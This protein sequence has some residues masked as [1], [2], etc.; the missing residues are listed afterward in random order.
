MTNG[1]R[2]IGIIIHITAWAVIFGMPLF[3]T[4][5][6]Q[7]VSWSDY[8][9]FLPVPFSFLI[10]F[11][12]NYFVLIRRFLFSH[13]VGLFLLYNIIATI[14][15]MMIVHA[16]HSL[17]QPIDM[18]N[19]GPRPLIGAISFYAG[20]IAMYLLVVG[21]SVA[22]RM[23]SEWYR[24]EAA[25]KEQ[26]KIGTE[27]ELQ[28]LKSQLNPHFLFNTLN[29]IYSLIQIDPEKA[30]DT[31]HDL[32][33]LLRYVLYE[34]SRETVPVKEE[35]KFLR[36]YMELMKIRLPKH[37]R[38]EVSLPEDSDK[39]IAPLLFI[40][41]IENAFKHGINDDKPSFINID[42][43][44]G[45]ADTIVCDIRNSNFPKED[46]DRSGSGIGL[47]NLCKRLEMIYPG[48]YTFGGGES[49]DEY[50]SHL[51]IKL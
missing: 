2:N 1:Q 45:D 35:M 29:N 41:L 50:H 11:Y 23:T 28:N 9:L 6:E 40:S 31:V 49:G 34:S 30:Q 25:R 20:N 19:R 21:A 44:F 39:E 27:A 13:K 22:I 10:L 37:V 43:H 4:H 36:N 24:T 15:L 14:A 3:M 17:F 12:L 8:L 33:T 48:A 26:E 47:S 7:Q 46:S 51:E 18:P 38:V 5:P 42:I 16:V 32:S